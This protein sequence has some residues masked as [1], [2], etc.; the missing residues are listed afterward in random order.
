[1]TKQLGVCVGVSARLSAHVEIVYQMLTSRMSD[2]A[3]GTI[4]PNL[5]LPPMGYE[6]GAAPTLC[7]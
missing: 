4:A 3:S 2:P 6:T 5:A 7:C 1:M